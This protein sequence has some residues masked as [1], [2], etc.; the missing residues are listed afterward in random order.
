[1][2]LKS[3]QTYE[4][5]A[6]GVL[7]PVPDFIFQTD[8]TGSVILG[9]KCSEI[10]YDSSNSPGIVLMHD[11]FGY[12]SGPFANFGT[13]SAIGAG[14]CNLIKDAQASFI[15][16]GQNNYIS[17]QTKVRYVTTAGPA[18][19]CDA[20]FGSRSFIGAGTANTIC[21]PKSTILGGHGNTVLGNTCWFG[22]VS[23]EDEYYT[24][25]AV[26]MGPGYLDVSSVSY[27]PG[28]NVIAGGKCNYLNAAYSIIGGGLSNCI[29]SVTEIKSSMGGYVNGLPSGLYNFIGG[30]YSNLI[31]NSESAVIA[32]GIDNTIN[33][34]DNS[35]LVGGCRNLISGGLGSDNNSL[36]GGF[37]NNIIGNGSYQFMGGGY[38][39]LIS[40]A[41]FS[42]LLGGAENSIVSNNLIG[43][44]S[45]KLNI[46]AGGCKNIIFGGC[47]SIIG[48]SDNL[49][50]NT[51]C[52]SIIA[53][54]NS[55]ITARCATI[56]GGRCTVISHTGAFV[57]ADSTSRIKNS[58][59]EN[60]L[61]LDFISGTYIKNKIILQGDNYIPSQSTS[62][63]ISG[64]IAYDSNYHYR[65]DGIKW[66]RT[67]LSEW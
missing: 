59:A 47:S 53:G 37:W 64:Q 38:R 12:W 43:R 33:L 25:N 52:S 1:M 61:T 40:G 16:A 7:K 57:I 17:G 34:S 14:S 21:S 36:V 55:T 8:T 19:F 60:T 22:G 2:S 6:N 48:G 20:S 63:G 31:R 5:E 54:S 44:A 65:H 23:P 62:F 39:N 3:V 29:E 58:P 18:A 27:G 50:T 24:G 11:A 66:K 42:A 32:G 51:I 56:L 30:G 46:I 15:G 41:G 67:A 28:Y 35:S 49:I 4:V 13:S 9:G 26:F 45:D 10:L